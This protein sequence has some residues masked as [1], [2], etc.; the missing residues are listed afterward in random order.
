MLSRKFQVHLR[1]Q[2]NIRTTLDRVPNLIVAFKHSVMILQ[3]WTN[4]NP[5]VTGC[6]VINSDRPIS[7]SIAKP[8]AIH[9][10]KCSNSLLGGKEGERGYRSE[11]FCNFK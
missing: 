5:P 11:N 7:K 1:S 4:L 3:H 2:D 6:L 10:A 8:T 9:G